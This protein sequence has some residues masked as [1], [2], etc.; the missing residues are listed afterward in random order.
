MRK[1]L[2]IIIIGSLFVLN[3]CEEDA[4]LFEYSGPNYVSF[5]DSES[6]FTAI[7]GDVNAFPIQIGVTTASDAARTYTVEVDA[8]ESTGIEGTH[9]NVDSKALTIEAGK[10]LGTL[11]ITPVFDALPL[12]GITVT[13]KLI[14]QDT[15][16]FSFMTHSV[17]IGKYCNLDLDAF[18]GEYTVTDGFDS[19]ICTI[20]R[21]PVDALFGLIITDPLSYWVGPSGALSIKLNACDNSVSFSKQATGAM[22]PSYGEVTLEQD[23][24]TT[25]DIATHTIN[26]SAAHTV[27]AGSF[28][29]WGTVYSKN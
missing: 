9:F 24:A 11:T 4:D 7:G 3:G 21:D 26:I 20:S 8:A 6:G 28:G 1:L 25:F 18:V 15:A 16:A 2:F 19:G 13:F 23:G 14:A 27:S 12:D 5:V 22:H 17:F 29:T 10:V